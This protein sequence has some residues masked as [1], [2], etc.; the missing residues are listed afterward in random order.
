MSATRPL[1]A[2]LSL[3]ALL[4]GACSRHDSEADAPAMPPPLPAEAILP[5]P[6][7]LADLRYP[8]AQDKITDLS[9]PGVFQHTGAG[10]QESGH[11]GSVRTG[12]SGLARFHEGID[13]AP[14][15]RDRRGR[16]LDTVLAVAAGS[17]GLVNRVA[18]NSD[19]G[20]YVVLVHDDPAGPVYTLYGH[21]ADITTGLSEGKTISA[22]EPVGLMGNTS[23]SGLPMERAHLHLEI[24]LLANQQFLSWPG[25]KQKT[26]PGGLYNGQ[27]L[28][29]VDPIEV[30]RQRF[31]STEPFSLLAHL[32]SHPVAF[33]LLIRARRQLVFFETHPALWTGEYYAGQ[34][35]V[36]SVSE[37]GLPLRGRN[38][39][40]EE[41]AATGKLS[42][43][44]LTVDPA[45]LGRN[46]RRHVV[47]SS[48]SWK[49]G[50]NG[51]TWLYILT[52]PG[53]LH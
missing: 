50:Q 16:P 46:G 20:K 52:H 7:A 23:L 40:P 39:T 2:S 44:V 3:C 34:A 19:Y 51:Q 35:M 6:P 15:Q 37:G 25:R 14:R 9:G 31:A 10:R 47:L 26:T 21:L 38:A 27:N 45:R 41:I 12:A 22:G 29:G 43:R 17:V 53:G 32:Q 18:G 5:A 28:L 48:G 36:L 24:G 33:E 42:H 30:Y 8:T 13:I 4:L 49:L 11:F 1:L